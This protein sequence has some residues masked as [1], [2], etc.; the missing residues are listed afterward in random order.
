MMFDLAHFRDQIGAVDNRRI[1]VAA[2]QHQMQRRRLLI[3]QRQYGRRRDQSEFNG[4][5]NFVKNDHLPLT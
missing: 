3:K 4:L 5:V 2:G 1:S